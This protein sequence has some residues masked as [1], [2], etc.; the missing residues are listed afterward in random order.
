M[1]WRMA[2]HYLFW[3]SSKPIAA[4]RRTIFKTSLF[5]LVVVLNWQGYGMFLQIL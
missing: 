5:L 3:K 4:L 1:S 2:T